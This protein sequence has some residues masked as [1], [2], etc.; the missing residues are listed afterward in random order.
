MKQQIPRSASQ[1]MKNRC[2]T[3]ALRGMTVQMGITH[4][5]E[6]ST[7]T[8]E[9]QFRTAVSKARLKYQHEETS[10]SRYK[11]PAHRYDYLI[12][13]A[14]LAS[15]G[16]LVL[17]FFYSR[18]EILLSG[19]AVAHLNIARRVFDSRTPG[20]MQLGTV[21]LPLPHLL[22][23]P[24]VVNQGLWTSGLGGSIPSVI[25]YLIA[26]LGLF[27]L[28]STWSRLAAWVGALIFAANP[29]VLCVQTTALNEP[30]YLACFA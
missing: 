6:R 19:D 3:A 15:T 13:A 4:F 2:F 27:R 14:L 16:L 21:W 28:L 9:F 29:N 22:I 25:S 23:I 10:R 1:I 26:G 17:W 18:N 5:R 11:A 12:A 20:P 8:H 7:A 30:M 24:F